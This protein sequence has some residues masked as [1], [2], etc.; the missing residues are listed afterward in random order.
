MVLAT[1][2][3]QVAALVA[4]VAGIWLVVLVSAEV[5]AATILSALVVGGAAYVVERD[6]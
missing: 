4:V 1:A 2:A 6:L 5:G 3:A